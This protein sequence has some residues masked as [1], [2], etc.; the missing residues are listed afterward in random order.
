MLKVGLTGGL[1]SGKSFVGETLR[2]LGCYLI[3][4]DELGHRT[5]DPGGA[6]Y[7]DVLSEFGPEI[8]RQDGTIDR[9]RLGQIVFS[10]PEK[11]SRLNQLIHPHVFR[12][13]DARIAEIAARD[14]DAIVVVEAAIMIETGSHERYHKLI[15]VVCT[16]EQ[17][18]ERALARDGLSREEV[19][20][21]MSRQIPLAEKIRYADYVIDNSGSREATIAQTREVFQKL[22]SLFGEVRQ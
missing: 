20:T 17:Q 7:Q 4:A 8:L 15:L 2:E 12:M 18:M 16:E 5:L 6:A 3:R 21:R 22:K 11:L 14:P 19:A 1:A 9:K 10:A 13:Q